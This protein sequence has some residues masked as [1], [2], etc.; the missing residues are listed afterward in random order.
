[1]EWQIRRTSFGVHTNSREDRHPKTFCILLQQIEVDRA[2]GVRLEER[3]WR[4]SALRN[5]MGSA[6][7]CHRARIEPMLHLA[8]LR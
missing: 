2:L 3:A 6:E 4:T 1:M 7:I 8:S 5:G